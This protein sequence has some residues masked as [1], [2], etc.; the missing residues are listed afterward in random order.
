MGRPL[1]IRPASQLPGAGRLALPEA[2]GLGVL[3]GLIT[4]LSAH[5]A[6]ACCTMAM[7]LV[8][9]AQQGG[10]PAAW[11]TSRKRCFYPPDARE[12]GIDLEA[13]AVV[14]VPDPADLG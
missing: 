9:E 10:E 12:N 1:R 4:E 13:L 11:I 14:R 2:W 6:S 5:G 3:K 7:R 8:L